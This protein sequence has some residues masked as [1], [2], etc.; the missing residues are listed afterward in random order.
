MDRTVLIGGCVHC[1]CCGRFHG[2][3]CIAVTDEPLPQVS[4]KFHFEEGN[5]PVCD[6]SAE[7]FSIYELA[8]LGESKL[9]KALILAKL[10]GTDNALIREGGE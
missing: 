5:C 3:A 4:P 7:G 10:S 9:R 8:E 1:I 2:L 6:A